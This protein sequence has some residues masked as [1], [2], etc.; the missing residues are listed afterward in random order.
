M[1]PIGGY[2]SS[3]QKTVA[4]FL[5]FSSV[6][7]YSVSPQSWQSKIR[8]VLQYD[9]IAKRINNRN[10]EAYTFFEQNIARF[11]KVIND[12]IICRD[13]EDNFLLAL[14]RD[15]GADFLITSDDDLLVL[16]KFGSTQILTLKEFVEFHN[17]K[18]K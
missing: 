5:L 8:S 2:H 3:F 17:G 11:F 12:V 10:L 6:I 15:S 4:T 13:H 9:P 16:K 14:S 1:I 7:S 18:A